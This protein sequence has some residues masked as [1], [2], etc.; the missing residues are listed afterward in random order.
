MLAREISKRTIFLTPVTTGCASSSRQSVESIVS[1]PVQAIDKLP[2]KKEVAS[3]M[4]S[5][6]PL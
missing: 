2:A 5:I 4:E 3:K 6:H 1:S